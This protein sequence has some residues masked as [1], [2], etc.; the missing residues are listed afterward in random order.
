MDSAKPIRIYG[1]VIG[2]RRN[3]ELQHIEVQK[4]KECMN[5]LKIDIKIES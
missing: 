2:G 5:A 1:V 3:I 4:R